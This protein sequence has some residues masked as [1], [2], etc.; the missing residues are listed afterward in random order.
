MIF[1]IISKSVH[2][3]ITQTFCIY[4]KNCKTNNIFLHFMSCPLIELIQGGR[5]EPKRALST[6][7]PPYTQNLISQMNLNS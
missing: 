4:K 1:Y 2:F 7:F 5:K 3:V 6:R